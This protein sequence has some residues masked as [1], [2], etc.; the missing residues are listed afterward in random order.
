LAKCQRTGINCGIIVSSKGFTKTAISKA[1]TQNVGCLLLDEVERFDWCQAPGVTVLNHDLIALSVR[2]NF[3]KDPGGQKLLTLA[4]GSAVTEQ[5]FRN[6][7]FHAFHT[8]VANRDELSG[9]HT[10]HFVEHNP[11]IFI[12]HP[13]GRMKATELLFSPTYNISRK[14]VPFEFRTYFDL[15]KSRAITAVAVAQV[16]VGGNTASMLLSRD[17][18]SGIVT[19]AIIPTA[20]KLS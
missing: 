10:L 11:A 1:N 9:I 7:A 18:T 13:M 2:V 17:E 6:W 15:A 8:H 19:V 3:Q 14:L 20:S 16:D 5:V 4:D 12:D